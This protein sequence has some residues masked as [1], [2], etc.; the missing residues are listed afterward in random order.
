MRLPSGLGWRLRASAG[1]MMLGDSVY[2]GRRGEMKRAQQIIVWGLIEGRDP[3][4]KWALRR[5]GGK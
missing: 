3:V 4:I 1:T 2:L 5:E